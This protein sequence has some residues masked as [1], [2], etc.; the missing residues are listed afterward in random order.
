MDEGPTYRMSVST[1]EVVRYDKN[2]YRVEECWVFK[3]DLLAQEEELSGFKGIGVKA[4]RTFYDLSTNKYRNGKI[5]YYD[6]NGKRIGELEPMDETWQEFDPVSQKVCAWIK[7]VK[8]I[9]K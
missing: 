2:I 8:K 3:G 6:R 4:V 5:I 1:K 9:K 7:E